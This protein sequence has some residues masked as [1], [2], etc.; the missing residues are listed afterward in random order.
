[1]VERLRIGLGGFG[2]C[3]GGLGLSLGK[4][5]L[6]ERH[7]QLLLHLLHLLLHLCHRAFLHGLEFILVHD[8]ALQ[9]QHFGLLLGQGIPLDA[10]ALLGLQRA[11]ELREVLRADFLGH[12]RRSA[13]GHDIEIA[14][15]GVIAGKLHV[16]VIQVGDE[17]LCY[18]LVPIDHQILE[19]NVCLRQQHRESA[20]GAGRP[21]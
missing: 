4:L 9:V 10:S 18:A 21:F 3:L 19:R 7:L 2:L 11:D 1:M 20:H 12:Q 13:L 16:P 14:L 15:D 17:R 8:D 5:A 6:H